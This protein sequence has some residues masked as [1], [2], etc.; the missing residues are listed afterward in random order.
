MVQISISSP[1]L[2]FGGAGF[3]TIKPPVGDVVNTLVSGVV[4]GGSGVVSI[5]LGIVA[6]RAAWLKQ[7]ERAF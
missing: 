7:V 5:V 4:Y 2:A 1:R 6:G 3:V